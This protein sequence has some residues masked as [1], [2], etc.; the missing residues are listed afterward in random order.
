MQMNWASA[1]L[2]R[3]LFN[4][5]KAYVRQLDPEERCEVLQPVIGLSLL[6]AVFEPDT[7]EFYP[8]YQMM[9]EGSPEQVIDGLQLVFVELPQF[10][11]SAM[12]ALLKWLRSAQNPGKAVLS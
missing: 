3:L 6:D 8:H 10:K 9:N 2:Q 5:S 1:F 7:K 11:Q 12:V 4:A